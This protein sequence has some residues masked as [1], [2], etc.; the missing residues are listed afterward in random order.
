MDDSARSEEAERA[1]EP[2]TRARRAAGPAPRPAATTAPRSP[3]FAPGAEPSAAAEA[4]SRAAPMGGAAADVTASVQMQ[5]PPV[6]RPMPRS[7][8]RWMRRVW[9]RV[10]DI[11]S[12]TAPTASEA[13]SVA[14]AESALA[15][16]PDS[17]DKHRALVR[18]ASR[19]GNVARARE[20]A[21]KWLGRDQLDP[22][23]L[24]FLSDAIGRDG[25]RDDA[26]R[27]LSGIV[28]LRPDDRALQ[29]RMAR[30]YD[31]AGMAELACAHRIAIADIASTDGAALGAAMR[32][33]RALGQNDSAT[34]LLGSVSDDA[35][36]RRAEEVAAQPT[37]LESVGGD[38]VLDASWGTATDLD[39]AIITPQGTRISWMGGRAT[40]SASDAGATGREKLALRRAGTGN[41]VLE[42]ARTRHDDQA[43]VSGRVTVSVMG[44]RRVIP[45]TLTGP[46]TVLGRAHITRE[47]RMESVGGSV[48]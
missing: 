11:Q 23:A 22:E 14:V 47:S 16:A 33:E 45:F 36:R 42:I 27:V 24:T 15:A 12:Q 9:F 5:P 44:T 39:L 40:V 13:R 34:R 29:D 17:R 1:P 19:A 4:P 35:A 26:L 41:Y 8:G 10:G 21:E 25:R 32:C 3:A 6:A 48:W 20:V 31:R 43:P 46:R 2:D 28:D 7:N 30:A 37:S 38:I 18:A